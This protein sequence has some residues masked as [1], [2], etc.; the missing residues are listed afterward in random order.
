M[1]CGQYAS[2]DSC[3]QRNFFSIIHDILNDLKT[4]F[5]FREQ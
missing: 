2:H 1:N 4:F 5:F 3:E